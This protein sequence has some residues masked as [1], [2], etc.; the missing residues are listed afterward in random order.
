[1]EIVYFFIEVFST[2]KT[3]GFKPVISFECSPD[4]GSSHN[5]VGYH[6]SPISSVAHPFIP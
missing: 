3:L 4:S 1:M 6:A 2:L 5:Y